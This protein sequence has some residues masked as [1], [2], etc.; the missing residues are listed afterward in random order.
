[1]FTRA[2]TTAHPAARVD[3]MTQFGVEWLDPTADRKLLERLLTFPLHIFRVGNRPRGLAR[4]L[5]RGRL[6]DCVRLRRCCSLHFPDQAAWFVQRADDYRRAFQRLRDSSS[7]A[8]FLDLP[9]LEP[10]LATLCAGGGSPTQAIILHRALDAGLFAA[11]R[12]LGQSLASLRR[13]ESG[14]A[15]EVYSGIPTSP[16]F[17]TDEVASALRA[18]A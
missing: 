15:V 17:G 14:D 1:M 6:P 4:A 10:L 3:F 9:G 12:E 16:L 2:M 7:C 11:A 8:T 5:G 13:A 18:Q